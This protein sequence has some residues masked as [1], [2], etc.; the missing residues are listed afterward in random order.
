MLIRPFYLPLADLLDGGVLRRTNWTLRILVRFVETSLVE[1]VLAEE[2]D[3]REVKRI[4]TVHAATGLE[5]NRLA[6]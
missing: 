2:V 5:N 4:T 1:R 3:G 6:S